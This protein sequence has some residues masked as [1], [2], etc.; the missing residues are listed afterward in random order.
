MDYELD[1]S[2]IDEGTIE[3]I[4]IPTEAEQLNSRIDEALAEMTELIFNLFGG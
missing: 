1:F 3:H 2:S 4:D